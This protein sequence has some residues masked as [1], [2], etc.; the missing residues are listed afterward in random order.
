MAAIPPPPTPRNPVAVWFQVGGAIFAGFGCMSLMGAVVVIVGINLAMPSDTPPA[1]TNTTSQDV[2]AVVTA[3]FRAIR[4]FI[5]EVSATLIFVGLVPLLL[6]VLFLIVGRGVA[7]YRPWSRIAGAALLLVPVLFGALAILGALLDHEYDVAPYT[8]P[9]V[10][11][12]LYPFWLLVS[13][14]NASLPSAS[15]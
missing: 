3:P 11:V 14:W 12:P 13:K 6:G 9:L 7:R 5:N 4:W 15:R 8:L 10:L 2:Y 1:G